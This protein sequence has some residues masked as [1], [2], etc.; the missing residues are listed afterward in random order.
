MKDD[1]VSAVVSLAADLRADQARRRLELHAS[2]MRLLLL[3]E[4]KRPQPKRGLW[5]RI[6]DRFRLLWTRKDRSPSEQE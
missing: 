1:E 3:F 2:A 4:M 5:Q 6:R